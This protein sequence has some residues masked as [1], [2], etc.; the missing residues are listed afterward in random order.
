MHFSSKNCKIINFYTSKP[1]FKSKISRKYPINIYDSRVELIFLL[2]KKK[3]AGASEYIYLYTF[4][5]RK[6]TYTVSPEN[7]LS[8]PDIIDRARCQQPTR[9][10]GREGEHTRASP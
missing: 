1:T 10:G 2:E 9:E 5:F 3:E 8:R 6:I 7:P 4:Y